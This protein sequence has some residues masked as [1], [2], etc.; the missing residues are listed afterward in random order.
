MQVTGFDGLFD[1]I[2]K[3]KEELKPTPASPLYDYLLEL[4]QDI[5]NRLQ[6]SLDEKTKSNS[7]RQSIGAGQFIEVQGDSVKITI[8]ANEYWKFINSGV[9]GTVKNQGAPYSFK[10]PWPNAKMAD[11]L[12][13]GIAQKGL[14][15][16]PGFKSFESYSYA[17]AT[18]IKRDGIEANYFVDEALNS[19]YL[20]EI[21]RKLADEFGKIVSLTLT[22]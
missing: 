13:Q 21:E 7:L 14:T 10:T 3:L 9:N 8:S 22:E 5:I 19:E 1:N 17:A 4:G 2:G 16:P 6:T 11:S 15:L 20:A 18:K 12:R